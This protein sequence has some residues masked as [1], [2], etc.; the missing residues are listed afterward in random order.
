MRRINQKI[1]ALENRCKKAITDCIIKLLV[2]L[3][4]DYD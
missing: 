1:A 3:I 2:K 4:N